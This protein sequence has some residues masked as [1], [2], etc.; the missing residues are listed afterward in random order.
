MTQVTDIFTLNDIPTNSTG[1]LWCVSW[2]G[3]GAVKHQ[4]GFTTIWHAAWGTGAY[5][6][7]FA[8][9]QNNETYTI[10][11][12]GQWNDEVMMRHVFQVVERYHGIVG[13][14]FAYEDEA[15]KFIEALEKHITWKMLS[16]EYNVNK[17]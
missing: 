14:G 12:T 8:L 16:K 1:V 13:V 10:N 11:D 7:S 6:I 3:R 17:N 15:Q 2:P 5:M 4:P 9:D